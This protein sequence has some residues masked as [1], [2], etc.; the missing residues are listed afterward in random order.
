[1]T[2]TMQDA[3]QTLP[4]GQFS[5]LDHTRGLTWRRVRR[6]QQQRISAEAVAGGET[7][8]R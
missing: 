6:T 7:L 8:V 5:I 2:K 4:C 3:T 1:M